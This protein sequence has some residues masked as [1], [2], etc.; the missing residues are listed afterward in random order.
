MTKGSENLQKVSETTSTTSL[1]MS[2]A[3]L[4]A[5]IDG[6]RRAHYRALGL[7]LPGLL[8]HALIAFQ[9][10][11]ASWRLQNLNRKQSERIV[12]QKSHEL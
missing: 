9:T 6:K 8:C 10:S 4:P 1:I 7:L 11:H 2:S 12:E 5:E 3:H